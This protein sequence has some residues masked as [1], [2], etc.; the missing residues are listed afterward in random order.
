MQRMKILLSLVFLLSLNFKA[1][2]EIVPLRGG[3]GGITASANNA[4]TGVNSHSGAESFTGGVTVSSFTD[5][6]NAEFRG[7]TG[8]GNATGTGSA[9]P[10]TVF[11]KS[12]DGA[13]Q[14]S[15]CLVNFTMSTGDDNAFLQFTST[16]TSGVA[17]TFGV[18]MESCTVGSYCRVAVTGLVRTIVN[19]SAT[20]GGTLATST[21]RCSSQNGAGAEGTAAMGRI[22]NA[23]SGAGSWVWVLLG[24]D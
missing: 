2:A 12:V 11:A 9:Q 23:G 16:V 13:T 1:H 4:F 5:T 3:G 21:T 17:G 10:V 24:V 22:L 8:L 6:G 20:V 14:S 7:L 19:G 15:G 18:L